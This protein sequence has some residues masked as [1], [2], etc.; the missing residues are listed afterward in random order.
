MTALRI[1]CIGA[2]LI[3]GFSL[4]CA[5]CYGT[6]ET[7]SIAYVL[8]IGVDKGPA[9]KS[10]GTFQM[11]APLRMGKSRQAAGVIGTFLAP[12]PTESRMYLKSTI[13]LTP[14]LTHIRAMIFSEELAREGM[15]RSFMTYNIR[16]RDFRETV[17]III[18]SGRAE[19]YIRHNKPALEANI[20]KFYEIH[21]AP[22][23][24]SSN[25]LPATY[26]EFYTRIKN[27]GASPYATYSGLNPLTGQ[28]RPAGAK[29][30]QQTGDAYLPGG[31][32]RRGGENQNPVDFSGLAVFR[33]YTMV[34]VL[35]SDE[36]RAVAILQGKFGSGY[37][38]VRDPLQPE[39]DF[40][41]LYVRCKPPQI[42]AGLKEGK[43]CFDIAVACEA[44]LLGITSGINYEA[45]G[46]RE[47]VEKQLSSLFREQITAMLKHT[48][49][50]GTDPVGLGLYLR[51]QFANTEALNQANLTDLYRTADIRVKV[52]ARLRH[53][54]LLWR[55][56]Q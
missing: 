54:G 8:V 28:D 38:G 29:T 2:A 32:P 42:T 15:I 26:H 20:A 56:T 24:E 9:G 18:V 47:L 16:N 37:L 35:N 45:H 31:I 39:K 51:P 4:L 11:A 49:E 1:R 27:A 46:R 50:L 19:D 3:A 36:T 22:T 5:G 43:A 10:I 12:A 41:S 44:E 21:L 52:D 33:D 48:Q 6:R 34:G 23:P 30:P 55:T 14:R 7:D 25:Y 53:P 40:L 17:F 13:P